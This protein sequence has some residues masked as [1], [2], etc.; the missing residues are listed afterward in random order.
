MSPELKTIYDQ[1]NVIQERLCQIA[2]DADHE[3]YHG[4]YFEASD[5]VR[6]AICIIVNKESILWQIQTKKK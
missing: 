1:L 6:A 2:L 4:S 5:K 3:P